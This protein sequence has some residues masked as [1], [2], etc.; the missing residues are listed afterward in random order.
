MTSPHVADD[1][2]DD[3]VDGLLD[4]PA[5]EATHAHLASCAECAARLA[6]LRDLL[7]LSTAERRAV[8]PPAELW[9]RVVASTIEWP[10]VRRRVLRSMRAPLLVMAALLVVL[11]SVATAW[12]VTRA[13][14]V[15]RAG[16]VV[17][18]LSTLVEEDAAFDR[19]LAELERATTDAA[20]GAR[21]RELRRGLAVADADLR[22]APDDETLFRA[23]AERERVLKEVRR[24]LGE[25]VRPPRAPTPPLPTSPI[26]ERR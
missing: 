18:S 1:R 6:E 19:A 22:G 4:A 10:R 25:P 16:A 12:V 15:A 14:A 8:E 24:V 11:S 5:L 7:A 26:V 23:L 20:E 2:L 13:S 21:V 9:P 3:Y 17:P